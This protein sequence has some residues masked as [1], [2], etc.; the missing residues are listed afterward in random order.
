MLSWPWPAPAPDGAAEHLVA[1]M[2]VPDIFLPATS[3]DQVSPARIPG[4]S[5]LTIYPWTGGP[6]RP[7]PPDWDNIPGAHGSTPQLLG[8]SR[9]HA[10]FTAVGVRVFG[11]SAQPPE[12]QREFHTRNALTFPLLSDAEFQFQ[13]ALDLPV[14]MAGDMTYLRRLT[15]VLR[16][17]HIERTYYPVHPPDVHGRELMYLCGATRP[18]ANTGR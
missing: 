5:I 2:K 16:D 15:L 18:G 13:N 11:L 6:D 4:R 1:G 12:E 3:G 17:G 7:N 9:L 10:G 8:V 14:F